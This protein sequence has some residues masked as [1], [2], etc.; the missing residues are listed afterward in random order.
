MVATGA[1][2]QQMHK[3]CPLTGEEHRKPRA[4]AGSREV[5]AAGFGHTVNSAPMAQTLRARY[6]LDMMRAL[7]HL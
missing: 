7:G 5:G 3:I 6:V 4:V 2:V 1:N